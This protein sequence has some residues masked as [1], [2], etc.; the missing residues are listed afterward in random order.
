MK[1]FVGLAALTLLGAIEASAADMPIKALPVADAPLEMCRLP[2]AWLNAG[3]C[4]P[5]WSI[6][7][8]PIYLQRSR[9]QS[10]RIITT[11]APGLNPV[12]SGSDFHFDYDSAPEIIVQWRPTTYLT[13][14][15]RYFN[16]R[17]PAAN[18]FIPN[19]TSF[20]TAGI[21]VT[22]LGGG[23][24]NGNYDSKLESTEFN[25]LAQ[26]V[27][28]ISLLAG[29]RY[30]KLNER[31]R[32]DLATPVTFVQWTDRNYLTG[33]QLGVNLGFTMP[34]IKALELNTAFKAGIYHNTAENVFGS[35]IVASNQNRATF[36]SYASEANIAA[37][38]R[39]TQNLS[40]QASYMLLWLHDVAIADKAAEATVQV[41][42]G[43]SSPVTKGNV[44]Y[45]GGS[46][47]A[48]L[49]F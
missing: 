39:F 33:G 8:G 44:W 38:Y 37:T 1:R 22:I 6:Y 40:I 35:T 31:L 5:A 7:A 45:Q 32:I 15:G 49:T 30:I 4:Q 13:F 21:G 18:D 48:G 29:A 24:L 42:G 26:I 11:P 36:K 23:S 47:R 28:G 27:P 25:A 17:P 20:R 12:I 16:N 3:P 41:P 46:V 14:E 2:M 43:T 10:T 9:P 19:I 34:G